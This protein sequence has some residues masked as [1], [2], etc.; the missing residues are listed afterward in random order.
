MGRGFRFLTIGRVFCVEHAQA[1]RAWSIQK[2]RNTQRSGV[3]KLDRGNNRCRS[4]RALRGSNAKGIVNRKK[5]NRQLG[6]R[7]HEGK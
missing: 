5:G 4:R 1:L 2:T 7:W 6:S 3:R